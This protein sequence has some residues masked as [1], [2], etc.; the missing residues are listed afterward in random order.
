MRRRTHA[1]LP[2]RCVEG[3][4]PPHQRRRRS[5]PCTRGSRR[6]RGARAGVGRS[7]RP[8]GRRT[9]RAS[10]R[11]GRRVFGEGPVE[12][13]A[14]ARAFLVGE[15]LAARSSSTATLVKGGRAGCLGGAPRTCT[16][17]LR[18]LARGW[19]YL[20]DNIYDEAEAS[21]D[22]V[23][24]RAAGGPVRRRG[25]LQRAGRPRRGPD[26]PCRRTWNERPR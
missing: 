11:R 13:A 25:V 6:R 22:L 19:P 21:Q 1:S 9:R 14:L 4:G 17:S 3:P 5:A 24:L 16:L 12:E 20:N 23:G 18:R 26:Q 8:R 2:A 7:L 10:T 15:D